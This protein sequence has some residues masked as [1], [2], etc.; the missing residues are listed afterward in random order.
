MSRH[1]ARPTL[2]RR[3]LDWAFRVSIPG[4]HHNLGW[5]A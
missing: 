4:R 1:A 2:F 5:P 3:V